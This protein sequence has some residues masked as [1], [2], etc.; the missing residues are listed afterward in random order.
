MHTLI[1]LPLPEHIRDWAETPPEPL[2]FPD[3]GR[4]VHET[5][6]WEQFYDLG[7]VS[8]E[9]NNGRLEAR[10]LTT[11]VKYRLYAWFIDILKD[12]LHVFPIARMVGLELGFRMVLPSKVTIRKPDL[13]VVLNS[14]LVPLGDEDRSYKGTFDICIESLSD[15]D[16]GEI[17]RD[18]II[19]KSEYAMAG[20]KEYY[21]L[22]DQHAETVFY[23]LNDQGIYEP[24]QPDADGVIR[25]TALPGFQFR[26]DDIYRQP[27]PPEIVSDPV[28]SSFISPYYRAERERAEQAEELLDELNQELARK[29]EALAQR[30]DE[31]NRKNEE[32]ARLWA[33][34][35]AAG[36]SLDET[37]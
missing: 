1:N 21:I 28:Y 37:E 25:S 2:R 17:D 23:R 4:I 10:P 22:D 16:Q 14:N 9:W 7:D 24:I 3:D 30:I 12:Y 26:L 15:S 19:K 29:D 13:G 32:N 36:L 5:I 11:Y 20:V 18:T 6:Y 35:K 27:M 8:Y 33:K 31:I 34:L